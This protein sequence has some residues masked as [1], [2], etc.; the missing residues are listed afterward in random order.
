MMDADEARRRLEKILRAT[1]PAQKVDAP[2]FWVGDTAG[3]RRTYDDCTGG[4]LAWRG[5]HNAAQ[6]GLNALDSGYPDMAAIYVLQATDLLMDALWSRIEPQDIDFLS[7][8]AKVRGRVSNTAERNKKLASAAA[9]QE[10]AGLSG[11]AA[12][13]AALDANPDLAEAFSGMGYDG[14]RKALSRGRTLLDKT[15]LGPKLPR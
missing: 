3:E 2:G 5:A 1:Q 8:S 13:N 4:R 10:S 7:N 9:V 11:K 15:K 6:H 12:C 14:I